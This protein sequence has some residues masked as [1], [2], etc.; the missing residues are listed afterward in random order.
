MSTPSVVDTMRLSSYGRRPNGSSAY[1]SSPT[2]RVRPTNARSAAT[3]AATPA[4]A[5]P[6]STPIT[7]NLAIGGTDI[8]TWHTLTAETGDD[9]VVDSADRGRPVIGQRL[10]PVARPEQHRLVAR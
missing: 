3:P 1:G 8:G 6:A 4:A 2:L 10:A 5:T 7:P 9:L